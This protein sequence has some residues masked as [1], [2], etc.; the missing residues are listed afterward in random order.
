MLL[1]NHL[2]ILINFWPYLEHIISA[3]TYNLQSLFMNKMKFISGNCL[4]VIVL[5]SM[6]LAKM[7]YIRR[8]YHI[9]AQRSSG[10]SYQHLEEVGFISAFLGQNKQSIQ[11]WKVFHHFT[12]VLNCIVW[13]E[14]N[15][16]IPIYFTSFGGIFL[17]DFLFNP[18]KGQRTKCRPGKTASLLIQKFDE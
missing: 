9:I 14:L 2:F 6:L 11:K 1:S 3:I 16:A 12:W 10:H 5:R 7:F 13:K 18:C 17:C 8:N 4:S 15:H